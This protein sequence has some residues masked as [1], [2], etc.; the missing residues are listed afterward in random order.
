MTDYFTLIAPGTVQ[1]SADGVADFN[2]RWPNSPLKPDRTYTFMFD[3]CG[4]LID[5]DVPGEDDG[6]AALVLSFDAGDW[7][8]EYTT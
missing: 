8:L 3:C 1:V 7:L 5:T 6:A 4:N 2:S